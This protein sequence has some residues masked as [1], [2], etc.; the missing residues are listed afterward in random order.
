MTRPALSL[1]CLAVLA[2]AVGHL[3]AEGAL[4]AQDTI[5]KIES[6]RAAW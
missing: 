6:G 4:R 3:A 2:L 1:L 5:Q